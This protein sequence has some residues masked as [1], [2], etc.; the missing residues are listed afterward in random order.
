MTSVVMNF[1]GEKRR[2]KIDE[3]RRKGGFIA[4]DVMVYKK[5]SIKSKTGKK[6]TIQ[7]MLE[8]YFIK[9][10]KI[11]TYFYKNYKE[12]LKIDKNGQECMLFSLIIF[13]KYNLVAEVD[14]KRHT[15]RD[16]IFQKKRQ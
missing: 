9:I 13:S 1:R 3:F 14:E 7:K 2:K 6:F 11:D 8:E 12:K 16:L 4:F 15:D 10:Y 5:Y